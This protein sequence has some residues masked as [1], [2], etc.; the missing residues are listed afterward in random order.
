[1]VTAFSA[2][3]YLAFPGEVFGYGLYVVASLPVFFLAA[4][5]IAHFWMPFFHEMRLTSV[6]E[7]FERRY[8]VRVRLLASL[9]FLLWRLFWM[10]TTLYA[11]ATMLAVMVGIPAY[12]VILCGGGLATL[13]TAV[14]G[15]RAVVWTDV[16][17]FVVLFSGIILGLVFATDQGLRDVIT[18]AYEG[19]RLKPFVPFDPEFLS[20]SP[21]VRMTLWSSLLGVFV[22]FLARYGADQVVMQ[23]YF[24]ARHLRDARRGLWL[25][26][27]AAVISLV[28]LSL[29]GL[30]LYAFAVNSGALEGIEALSASQRNALMM[31]QWSGLIRS[32]P[33]G[34]TGLVIAGLLAATMSSLDSGVN[35][36][37][38]ACMTDL[39]PR[40]RVGQRLVAPDSLQHLL[41][42]ALGSLTVL[43]ALLFIPAVSRHN[44]LFMLVNKMING[45][46]S[47][48]LCLFICG[49]FLRRTNAPGV[50][51]GGCI[52]VV[53]SLS[54]SLG[55]QGLSLQYYAL[56]NLMA[57]LVPCVLL[58]WVVN[59]FGYR[60]HPERLRWTWFAWRSRS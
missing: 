32:F 15:M 3:N 40:L 25:N 36:C 6:Y 7:Y 46:G 27:V 21:F 29:F 2:I 60:D 24:S 16:A 58:S 28:L 17:Q 33:N 43:I 56:A 41:T 12:V 42:L 26:A 39:Y 11:T 38:A 34:V 14:G 48:L 47:P 1:M 8:D 53:A 54:I 52:G 59:C 4:W 44:S 51:W 57:A 35:A 50:F 13:Y 22:A 45:M 30:A 20:P 9:L 18:L 19:G 5:P 10:A 31:R 55:V 49:M 37:S 23:R